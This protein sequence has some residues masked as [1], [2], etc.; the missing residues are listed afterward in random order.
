MI[1]FL[2]L[3]FFFGEAPEGDLHSKTPEVVGMGTRTELIQTACTRLERAGGWIEDEGEL[4]YFCALGEG[5]RQQIPDAYWLAPDPY[6]EWLARFPSRPQSLAN[7][8]PTFKQGHQKANELVL[9]PEACR[10]YSIISPSVQKGSMD[11]HDPRTAI[12]SSTGELLES[13]Q[14]LRQKQTRGE[15]LCST[16]E[17]AGHSTQSVGLD[18]IFGIH[19]TRNQTTYFPSKEALLEVGACLRSI[20]RIDAPVFFSTCGGDLARDR[21]GKPTG[22]THFWPLKSRAQR[23]LSQL[24]QMTVI[25]GVGHVSGT[26]EGGVRSDWG[27]HFTAYPQPRS[28]PLGLFSNL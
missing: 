1:L 17:F 23:E 12:V 6:Q 2:A 22:T 19:R 10:F 20:S 26:E 21:D 7:L 28:W 9:H 8:A 15:P 3:L 16:I 4:H 27:W 25:S 5:T 24:L 18:L 13:C 14:R 11:P